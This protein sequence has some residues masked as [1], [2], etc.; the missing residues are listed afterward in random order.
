ME[1]S[2]RTGSIMALATNSTS[3]NELGAAHPPLANGLRK[4]IVRYLPGLWLVAVV[5]AA[6]YG[7]RGF[8]LLSALS[9]MILGIILGVV[10]CNLV[11]LPPEVHP[12]LQVSGRTLLRGAVAL[13][14]LQVTLGEM[15]TLGLWGLA[16]TALTL[17]AT[18]FLTIALGRALGVAAPLTSLI[19]AGTS[20]C[21]AAAIAGVNGV[22]RAKDEDVTYAVA[23]ITLF[24]TIAMFLYPVIGEAIG[25]DTAE[26][27]AWIGL[28]VHEVAQVVGAGFQHGDEAGRLA[29]IVKLARVVL[30]AALVFGLSIRLGRIGATSAR[31]PLVPWFVLAFLACSAAN[32]W[33][34]VPQILRDPLV[35][36]TPVVLTAALSALGLGTHFG[37]LQQLGMRPLLLCA[38]STGFIA[39]LSLILSVA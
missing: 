32:S 29:V 16:S 22:L 9:P 1:I 12:G 3:D 4:A 14:G 39:A 28:S 13:L 33:G 37:R 5:T 38:L 30:L 2:S 15:A 36:I 26:Y 20:V 11:P 34:L 24:G 27:G 6:A 19:A 8:P 25:L 10:L 21:G 18:F 31:P 35:A 17:F 23:A 7:L